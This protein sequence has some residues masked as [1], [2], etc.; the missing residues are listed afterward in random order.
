MAFYGSG[1]LA[2]SFLSRLLVEL[3]TTKFSQNASLLTGTLETTQG[4]V[5]IFILFYANTRH[6]ILVTTSEHKETRRR[7]RDRTPHDIGANLNLQ[8]KNG[9][10]WPVSGCRCGIMRRLC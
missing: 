5:K 9:R 8:S 1:F 10:I 4:S 7:G 3:A 2:F 6:T